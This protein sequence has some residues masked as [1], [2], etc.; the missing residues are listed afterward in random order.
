M[1]RHVGNAALVVWAETIRS[2]YFDQVLNEPLA[3]ADGVILARL[4]FDYQQP[5]G[6]REDIAIACRV[7]RMGNKSFDFAYEIWS[8]TNQARAAHGLTT[9]VAYDYEAKSSIVIPER[10]REIIV[11]YEVVSP[12]VG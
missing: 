10:W 3:V 8:E 4:A 7:A 9:M 2:V 5:L 12:T 6:Y 11:A 1:A